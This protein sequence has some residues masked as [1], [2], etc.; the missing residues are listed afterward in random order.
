MCRE[1]N[2]FPELCGKGHDPFTASLWEPGLVFGRVSGNNDP[3]VAVRRDGEVDSN[4]SLPPG[5]GR[6]TKNINII[7]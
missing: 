6:L 5:C 2:K 4:V 3:P 1:N 7:I